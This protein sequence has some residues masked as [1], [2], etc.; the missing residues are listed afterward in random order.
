MFTSEAAPMTEPRI[1]IATMILSECAIAALSGEAK[2]V[3]ISS[4]CETEGEEC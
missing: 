1:A 3:G 4:A 2:R